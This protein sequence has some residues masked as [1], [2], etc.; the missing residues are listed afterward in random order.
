MPSVY[1]YMQFST[2]VYDAAAVNSI[3]VPGGWTQVDWVPDTASGFSAG[4][5]RNDSTGEFVIAYTGTNSSVMDPLSWLAGVG[6]P[7]GQVTDAIRYYLTFRLAN[8]NAQVTF[9]G[10]S[11]GGGLASLMSV[12]FDKSAIVFDQAPFQLAA[13]NASIFP[14]Y[15]QTMLDV[16][17]SDSAF[18][19]F[20]LS[21]GLLA[22]SREANVAHYY[23]DG[24]IL[25]SIRFSP[26]TFLSPPGLLM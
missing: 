12:F 1:E 3:D 8:P 14:V 15:L 22:L 16:G 18:N 20:L 17:Y 21:G 13:T 2:R 5:F 19:D 11:L 7:M 9:T 10:H 25:N 24:E 23:L 4:I 6:I 26:L